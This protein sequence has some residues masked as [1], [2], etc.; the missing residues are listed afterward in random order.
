MNVVAFAAPC[1]IS[2]K[3]VQLTPVQRSILKP[4]SFVEV[5]VHARAISVLDD[6]VAVRLVGAVG[7][8]KDGVV[9]FAMFEYADV[10]LALNAWTRYRYVVA[11]ASPVSL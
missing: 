2:A 11:A 3:V 5:S 7:G 1:A 8:D 4:L 10:A 6:A 9:A